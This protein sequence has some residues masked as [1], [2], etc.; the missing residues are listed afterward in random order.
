PPLYILQ[1][2]LS[3]FPIVYVA[4]AWRGPRMTQNFKLAV[5]MKMN[6]HNVTIYLALLLIGSASTLTAQVTTVKIGI[7]STPVQVDPMIYGQM[8]ENVND[9]MIYG[10]VVDLAGN[11]RTH[12]IPDLRELQIPVMR[13][14]GGTVVHEYHWENGI[15]PRDQRPTV[16]NLAWGGVENYQ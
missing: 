3:A 2:R 9:S 5:T 10:G 14:P 8:L 15:G 13:W 7:P 11:V 6:F 12:L 4:V 16:P 1:W